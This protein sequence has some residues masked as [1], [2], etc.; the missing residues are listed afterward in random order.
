MTEWFKAPDSKSKNAGFQ[1]FSQFVRRYQTLV[2]IDDSSLCCF[3]T[4]SDF[5]SKTRNQYQIADQNYFVRLKLLGEANL[6]ESSFFPATSSSSPA[7]CALAV[8]CARVPL[9]QIWREK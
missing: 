9:H 8:L 4:L 7:L 2:I 5:Y 3:L 6:P 1:T